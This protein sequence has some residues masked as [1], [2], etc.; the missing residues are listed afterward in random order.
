M[1]RTAVGARGQ[2]ARLTAPAVVACATAAVAQPARGAR[3]RS[4][5]RRSQVLVACLASPTFVARAP[6]ARPV[7]TPMA[8]AV[9]RARSRLTRAV[10]SLPAKVTV[11][12]AVDAVAVA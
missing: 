11:A 10:G 6:P 7:T 9:K 5:T 1:G 8:R 12:L 4:R 3:R 2:V